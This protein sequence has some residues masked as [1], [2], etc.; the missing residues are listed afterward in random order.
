MLKLV[1]ALVVVTVL[2]RGHAILRLA[3]SVGR[4]VGPSFRRSVRPS[5]FLNSERFLHYCSC[6]THRDRIAVYPALFFHQGIVWDLRLKQI[7]FGI[8]D[9]GW[10]I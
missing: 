1:M 2:S 5:H 6:P 7:C 9:Y 3:V 4:S 8:E 10:N